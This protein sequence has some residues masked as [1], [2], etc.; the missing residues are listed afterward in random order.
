MSACLFKVQLV[1]WVRATIQKMNA[2]RKSDFASWSEFWLE[3]Y[4]ELGGTKKSSGSKQ[5][6]QHAAYPLWQLGRISGSGRPTQDRTLQEVNREFGKNAAYAI[7]ALNLLEAGW[8]SEDTDTLWSE[9]KR[10]YRQNLSEP[11]AQSQQGA[12]TIVSILFAEGQIVSV[13]PSKNDKR[14]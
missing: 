3:T 12:V 10:L 6:P 11:P 8:P 5:C 14:A 13:A 7:L 1:P 2:E 4:F 9:V